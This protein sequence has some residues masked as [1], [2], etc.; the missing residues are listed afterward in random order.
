MKRCLPL[1]LI[2][3]AACTVHAAMPRDFDLLRQKS[4]F[5]RERVRTRSY[6]PSSRPV[7]PP[8]L[9]PVLVGIGEQG[10]ARDAVFELP[11][12]GRSISVQPGDRL[13]GG[14]LVTAID[15][16]GVEVLV[17][18]TRR[19]LSV[20]R[21]LDGSEAPVLQAPTPPAGGGSSA[22]APPVEG[23][24]IISRMRRRRQEEEGK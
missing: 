23:E 19:R 15:A 8:S 14:A 2:A 21:S 11:S 22:S 17:G 12:V 13:P 4:I 6:E 7:T 9:A 20:G 10:A 1:L 3:S 18:D 16:D 24:D 5:S